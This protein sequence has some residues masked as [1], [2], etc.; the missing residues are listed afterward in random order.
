MK[1]LLILTVLVVL[2]SLFML[3]NTGF[4]IDL[5]RYSLVT[6]YEIENN[7]QSWS[8]LVLHS[9][10]NSISMVISNSQA[11][12]ISDALNLV[13]PQRPMTH[14]LIVNILDSI[15]A[16]VISA[17]IDRLENDYYVATLHIK[18]GIISISVD[19]RPSDFIAVSLRQGAPVFINKTLFYESLPE[20]FEPG[21]NF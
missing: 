9:S 10:N 13:R 17:S 8:N 20:T 5:N 14:D 12:A 15:G 3:L 6:G 1:K 2:I 7:G 21:F 4:M 18:V 19:C 11:A 16:N